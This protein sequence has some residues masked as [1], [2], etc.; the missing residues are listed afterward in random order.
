MMETLIAV[1]ESATFVEAAKRL[2]QSQSAVSKSLSELERVLSTTLVVRGHS[3]HR[4]TP[5]GIQLLRTAKKLVIAVDTAWASWC[6]YADGQAGCVNIA[7]LPS[8]GALLVPAAIAEFAESHPRVRLGTTDNVASAL[9]EIAHEQTIDF[10]VT[11]LPAASGM[12]HIAH[13]GLIE[14]PLHED[15]YVA[16]ARRGHPLLDADEVT[17][18]DVCQ[19]PLALA[20]SQTSIGLAVDIILGASGLSYTE[21]S[22]VRTIGSIGGMIDTGLAVSIVPSLLVKLFGF[23]DIK[24][25][26]IADVSNKRVTGI[27]RPAGQQLCAP[28]A[29]LAEILRTHMSAVPGGLP[30]YRAVEH[31]LPV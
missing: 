11:F 20:S 22:R 17:L 3:G 10:I 29:D 9:A 30:G 21:F 31:P 12:G 4:L 6:D 27:L 18:A 1:A 8:A 23:T 5:D 24:A 16:V 14:E 7:F 19:Y 26:P 25:K 2:H 13:E 15:D 28:A